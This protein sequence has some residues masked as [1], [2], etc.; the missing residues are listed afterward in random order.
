MAQK[1]YSTPPQMVIDPAKRYMATFHTGA[2]DFQVELFAAQAPV[3]VNNFVFLAREGFYNNTTF[4][5]V[6]HN[7]M[8]QGGDPTGTGTGG[9][10][11]KFNDERGALSLKHDSE[12]ILSM[13]NAG[14]NTNG[15]Q[16]FI[17]YGPTPHLNGKHGVFGKVISGLEH[18]RSINERDPG[19]SREPGTQIFSIDISES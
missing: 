3:T 14:A 15:S 7:F 17:T 2:G 19:R 4:H 10:G 11:Y 12:G 9:P 13:A 8:A 6:M 5:R 16:F 18:V 1:Q